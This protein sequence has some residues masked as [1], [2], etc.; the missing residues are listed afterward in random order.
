MAQSPFFIPIGTERERA[1]NRIWQAIMEREDIKFSAN[2]GR[3]IVVF[4][5]MA[6]GK[7][8]LGGAH[9]NLLDKTWSINSRGQSQR[10]IDMA[11]KRRL[12]LHFGSGVGQDWMAQLGGAVGRC[13]RTPLR[14]A[15]RR[16]IG[17][18]CKMHFLTQLR[19]RWRRRC[20]ARCKCTGTQSRYTLTLEET[21][22]GLHF[23]CDNGTLH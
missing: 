18:V 3:V 14:R 17:C 9:G 19:W 22:M 7:E 20:S 23:K 8:K 15:C 6:G 16:E 12:Q 2:F 5:H 11:A 4:A 1:R 13:S 21:N 10:V